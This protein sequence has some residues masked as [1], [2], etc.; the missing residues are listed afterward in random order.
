[1][2]NYEFYKDGSKKAK[3]IEL[4]I[5]H[6]RVQ[7]LEGQKNITLSV[8]EDFDTSENPNSWIW[9]SFTDENETSFMLTREEAARLRDRLNFR[10]GL[11]YPSGC[12]DSESEGA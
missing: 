7:P 9:L 5:P 3:G 4:S 12:F 1:M 10:V 11:E 6:T 2:S 8:Q